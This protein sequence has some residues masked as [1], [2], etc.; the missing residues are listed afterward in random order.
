MN[1]NLIIYVL[2]IIQIIIFFQKIKQYLKQN[3]QKIRGGNET[4]NS[5]LNVEKNDG[6][7]SK[8]SKFIFA[9]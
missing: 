6:N 4:K 1:R 9:L 8:N 5:K 2:F 7:N 3:K